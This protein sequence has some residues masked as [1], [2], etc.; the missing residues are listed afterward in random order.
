MKI[1]IR[2]WPI[3]GPR[4]ININ[5]EPFDVWNF[6]HTF[7]LIAYPALQALKKTK[8]G[9]PS[10]F[11]IVGGEDWNSQRCFDFYTDSG[12]WFEQRVAQ[13]ETVLDK[14]IWSFYEIA[15][16]LGEEQYHPE[17][18]PYDHE[19]MIKYNERIQEGLDLFAK[20]YQSLWT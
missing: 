4:K 2:D 9:I 11:A 19:G 17:G 1:D 7:A 12:E 6:D 15:F 8:Q 5:I 16:E 13:W 14:M 20:Y 3:S 10:K 18:G